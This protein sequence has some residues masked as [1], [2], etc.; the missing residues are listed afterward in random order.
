MA[1]DHHVSELSTGPEAVRLM[2]EIISR[3]E[4]LDVLL[5][6]I[7]TYLEAGRGPRA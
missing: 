1:T 2:G 6:E 5:K 3:L 7:L 4:K